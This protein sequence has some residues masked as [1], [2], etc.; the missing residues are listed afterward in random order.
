[1]RFI[2]V[3]PVEENV[4][5]QRDAWVSSDEVL[6]RL[7]ALGELHPVPNPHGN[8]PARTFA[9]EGAPGSV[10]VISPLAHDYC[11]TCNRVRLSADGHLKL[12]LFGDHLIDLRTPLREGGG[13][14]AIVALLRGAMHVKPERHHLAL[15]ETAS[16]MRAFSEIGG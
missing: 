14:D 1:V 4:G 6:E 3:M 9:Y 7:R 8:G 12:C 5:L 11:E 16:V 13:E 10:G 2:E 15:G